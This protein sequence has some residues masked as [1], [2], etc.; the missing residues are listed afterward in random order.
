VVWAYIALASGLHMAYPGHG[1]YPDSY[2]PRQRPWYR[3]GAQATTPQWGQPYLDVS[4]QGLLLAC[5]RAIIS[6]SGQ[7]LGVVGLDIPLSRLMQ[8]LSERLQP[9]RFSRMLLLSDS[10]QILLEWVNGQ[11]RPPAPR[12][13]QLKLLAQLRTRPAGYMESDGRLLVWQRI[14]P[15][16]SFY[17]VEKTLE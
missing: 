1:G 7:R 2:D 14:E 5:S 11:M 8:Q 17:L 13:A 6:D 16:R 15:L 9:I 4:G 12:A 3:I 10:G